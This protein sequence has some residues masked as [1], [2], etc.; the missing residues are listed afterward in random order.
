MPFALSMV[1][2]LSTF[3]KFFEPNTRSDVRD[4]L[5]VQINHEHRDCTCENEWLNKARRTM[6]V[7]HVGLL[8]VKPAGVSVLSSCRLL[9]TPRKEFSL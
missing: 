1:V 8:S 7:Y 4:C 2:L 6:Y 5:S 3:R 9:D